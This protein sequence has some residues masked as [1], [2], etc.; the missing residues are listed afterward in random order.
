LAAA[1][2]GA[3]WAV[4]LL[5]G[6]PLGFFAAAMTHIPLQAALAAF[7]LVFQRL[8]AVPEQDSKP[9]FVGNVVLAAASVLTIAALYVGAITDN[10]GAVWLAG[11]AAV[12]AIL[13]LT[14][15][16]VPA[17]A[18]ATAGA[19]LL[20]LAALIFWPPL[21]EGH[22][23]SSL[24][25]AIL[26]M[27]PPDETAWFA[28]IA[29]LGSLAIAVPAAGRL[30]RG[31]RLPFVAAVCYAGAAAL[32]PIGALGI[33][34]LRLAQGEASYPLA[35]V[36]AAGTLAFAAGAWVFLN[37]QAREPAQSILL[38]LGALASAAATAIA[39]ALV[40]ALEGGLLTV[41]LALAAAG[42]SFVSVRFGIDALRWCVAGFGIL[43][44]ARLAWDPRIVGADLSPTPI[45]N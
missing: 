30:Y 14:A 3:A 44:A 42:T 31:A 40:F 10:F 37:K 11:G 16:R 27:L 41:A 19:G 24:V 13:A 15:L 39:L 4:L 29:L 32:T 8:H 43:V 6:I 34:Y 1:A 2:G 7:F 33:A 36:A 5:G 23:V 21:P 17:A 9:D 45:F 35:A 22:V 26:V 12:T 25:L 18:S 28:V 38:G 20:V